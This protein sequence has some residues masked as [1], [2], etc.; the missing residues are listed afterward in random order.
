MESTKP[1]DW[2]SPEQRKAAALGTGL[3][4]DEY[5][6]QWMAV[7]KI[8][9]T[10]WMQYERHIRLRIAPVL[11]ETSLRRLTR[12]MIA[13]WWRK[14]DGSRS[15]DQAYSLLRTI[16]NT[17]VE[18]GLLKENPCAVKGAGKPSKQRSIDPPD[19]AAVQLVADEMP[20]RWRIGVLLAAWCG[21]R[22][23]EVRELRRKDIVIRTETRGGKETTVGT[24]VI[25]RAVARAGTRLIIG[26]T[27]TDAGQRRVPIPSALIPAVE[28]HLR[29]WVGPLPESLV[30]STEDDETVHDGRWNRA[31]RSAA[32]RALA[33]QSEWDKVMTA[34]QG[35]KGR[36][37]LPDWEPGITFHD[38]R[39]VAMTNAGIAGA[40]IKELQAMAGHTTPNMAMRYQEVARSHLD[41]VMDRVSAMIPAQ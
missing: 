6:D 16:L 29:D 25:D 23:G 3:T 11:G 12:Q 14:L 24:I 38:L 19:P 40:T 35:K 21:P 32:I 15:D 37:P 17:A 36:I 27:K 33:P 8:R 22:S 1:E 39:H 10:T 31:F 4:L 41:E 5:M 2:V 28:A 18:D 34:H 9:E 7:T 30:I 26:P 20:P 13:A